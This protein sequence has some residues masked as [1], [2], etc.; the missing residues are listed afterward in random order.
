VKRIYIP[1]TENFLTEPAGAFQPVSTS[2]FALPTL[3]SVKTAG[4]IVKEQALCT[5][6]VREAT[7]ETKARV[8]ESLTSMCDRTWIAVGSD[9]TPPNASFL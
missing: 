8:K 7:R 9:L 1:G 2:G 6:K 4:Q 3:R 5:S